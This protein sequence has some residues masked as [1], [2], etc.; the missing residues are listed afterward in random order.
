MQAGQEEIKDRSSLLCAELSPRV[1][2]MLLASAQLNRRAVRFLFLP[3]PSSPHPISLLS[4]K[5]CHIE[6]YFF[7]GIDW[8][9]Q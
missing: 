8:C 6:S 3:A 9:E 1:A 4:E 2:E 7:S 5:K